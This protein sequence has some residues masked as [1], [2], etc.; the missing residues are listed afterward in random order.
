MSN[1]QMMKVQ[2]ES[3]F[4]IWVRAL[5][6]PREA[7]FAELATSPKA[8]GA[9]AYLWVFLC[10]F[11]PAL[12]SVIVSG[13]E[14]TRRLAE[15]GVDAEQIG[16]GL[17][18]ALINLVCI[19]PFAAVIGAAGFLISVAITQWIARMF[20]GR[21]SHDQLAYALGA[22]A[23]PALLVT[24]LLTLPTAI[25]FVGLCFAGLSALFSIY[26][27]VLEV[28]AIKGVHGFGWGAAIGSLLIPGLAIGLVCC[29]AVAILLAI[30]GAAIGD[31]WSTINLSSMY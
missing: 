14:L 26:V 28:I 12:V 9:T 22:V 21:G 27:I 31:V 11:A 15:A 3:F 17:G 2:T 1:D 29:C 23:A 10:S 20:G 24:A 7:T 30:T 8:R 13:G 18:G 5:T 16:G 19:T 6:R 25:P 4:Q